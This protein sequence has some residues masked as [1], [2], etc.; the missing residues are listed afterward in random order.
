MRLHLL[1]IESV[2][3]KMLHSPTLFALLN[4]SGSLSN[5]SARPVCPRCRRSFGAHNRHVFLITLRFLLKL[6][7]GPHALNGHDFPEHFS[8][9]I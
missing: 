8:F 3:A 5:N 6:L 7:R 2:P 1:S 4:F 9:T